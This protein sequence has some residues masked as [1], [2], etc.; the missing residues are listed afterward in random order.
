M[1]KRA[2]DAPP[3]ERWIELRIRKRKVCDMIH[4]S[5]WLIETFVQLSGVVIQF[6]SL[7]MDPYLWQSIHD[8]IG[9]LMARIVVPLTSLFSEQKIRIVVLERGWFHA[10][11]VALK[12]ERLSQVKSMKNER[13]SASSNDDEISGPFPKTVPKNMFSYSGKI[14]A[15]HPTSQGIKVD[16]NIRTPTKHSNEDLSSTISENLKP[17]RINDL[18]NTLPDNLS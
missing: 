13:K 1:K 15:G 7:N 14:N 11:K 8:T 4:H 12:I 2:D 16:F 10:I 5:T 17:M 9:L 18:P 6:L 3:S